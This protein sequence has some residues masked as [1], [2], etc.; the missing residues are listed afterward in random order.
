MSRSMLLL[1]LASVLTVAGL[2][3][4]SQ[5]QQPDPS[6]PTP[7][8]GASEEQSMPDQVVSGTRILIRLQDDL[9]TKEDKKG[10]QFKART[11][12]PITTASGAILPAGAEVFGHVDKV[13]SAG[14]VGRAR[15]WLTFDDIE[16]RGGRKPLVA[17]LIDAPGV[18]SVHV[19]FDH[20]GEIE[21]PSSKRQKE[22]QAAAQGALVGASAGM[23][24]K[25]KKDAAIGAAIGA[26]NAFMAESGLGQE[27]LLQTG[28]KLEIVLT[29]PLYLGGS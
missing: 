4:H 10:K 21:T 15:I 27:L 22:E 1:C 5:T 26:A 25:D 24:A 29:R 3:A 23:N 9:S 16:T 18:H 7:P 28:T 8:S 19:V 17:E 14:K 20:E 13:E 11:L 2:P 12:Q 6:T